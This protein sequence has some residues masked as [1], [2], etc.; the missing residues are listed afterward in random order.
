[1]VRPTATMTITSSGNIDVTDYATI[2]VPTGSV[3]PDISI[4]SNTGKILA[5]ITAEEGY[6]P[7]GTITTFSQIPTAASGIFAATT[8]AQT[9]VSGKCLTTGSITLA[10]IT[11]ATLSDPQTIFSFPES[12]DSE[13]DKLIARSYFETIS[14]GQINDIPIIVGYQDLCTITCTPSTTTQVITITDPNTFI[15]NIIVEPASSGSVIPNLQS[16]TITPSTTTQ[17]VSADSSYD[18]L[19]TVIVNPIP[20]NYVIP[21]G[22]MTITNNGNYNVTNTA[23][24]NVN[25]DKSGKVSPF[26]NI[27]ECNIIATASLHE[28]YNYSRATD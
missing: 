19:E 15:Q 11:P 13:Q 27:L 24:V 18:G 14:P 22:T 1:M 2:N 25:V 12:G 16:K 20:T 21:S 6:I 8:S 26:T 4:N 23:S 9:I 7:S 17:T 3:I 5:T 10:A 28:F